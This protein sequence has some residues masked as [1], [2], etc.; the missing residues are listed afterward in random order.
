MRRQI[1]KRS[2]HV[3]FSPLSSTVSLTNTA[4][5]HTL[6][7]FCNLTVI[8]LTFCC[9]NTCALC[10]VSSC[11]NLCLMQ[12]GS[13][14]LGFT[15]LLFNKKPP[16]AAALLARET[17]FSAGIVGDATVVNGKIKYVP[18]S[19]WWELECSL[20]APEIRIM[21]IKQ[22]ININNNLW[23]KWTSLFITGFAFF[24]SVVIK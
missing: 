18:M 6:S 20:I 11:I 22:P 23:K 8:A 13:L 12:L 19:I 9:Y 10:P 2:L 16:A 21:G 7:S 4:Q 1:F 17:D 14:L 5:F 24:K 3:S 15:I